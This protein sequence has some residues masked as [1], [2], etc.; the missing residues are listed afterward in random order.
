MVGLDRRIV[1]T[2]LGFERGDTLTHA[3]FVATLGAGDGG[4][5]FVESFRWDDLCGGAEG[6][7]DAHLAIRNPCVAG[8]LRAYLSG[9]SLHVVSIS[10]NPAGDEA[11]IRYV[12]RETGPT[13]IELVDLFGRVILA[14]PASV[15]ERGEH[16]LALPL[17]GLNDGEY[18][19][20]IITPTATTAAVVKVVR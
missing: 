1:L 7:R 14:L 3:D 2:G 8:G 20:R 5:V 19:M 12:L 4:T 16:R 13:A 17:G 6:L 9:D 11:E 18:Y 10:P 15:Q